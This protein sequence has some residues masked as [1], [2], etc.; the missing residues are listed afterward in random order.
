MCSTQESTDAMD[1][2]FSPASRLRESCITFH[3]II[4]NRR[5][6]QETLYRLS[7][8]S[9]R[10]LN[11]VRDLLLEYLTF[12]RGTNLVLHDKFQ[13]DLTDTFIRA[14]GCN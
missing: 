3:D 1:H 6:R 14:C 2:F 7:L 10:V 8:S 5:E 13:Q 12:L 11:E 4:H 9:S